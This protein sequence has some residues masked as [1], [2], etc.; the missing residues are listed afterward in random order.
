MFFSNKRTLEG[1][2][3]PEHP[4]TLSS[5]RLIEPSLAESV[6]LPQEN[7]ILIETKEIPQLFSEFKEEDET[8]NQDQT[9]CEMIQSMILYKAL[10]RA[11]QSIWNR[12]NPSSPS[13]IDPHLSHAIA[14]R[15]SFLLQNVFRRAHLNRRS[16]VKL[17]RK[18]PQNANRDLEN[19]PVNWE[20]LREAA[21]QIIGQAALDQD[22]FVKFKFRLEKLFKKVN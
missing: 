5:S 19:V 18:F 14:R 13:A 20:D 6:K 21:K 3:W 11:S 1:L 15:C 7:E 10:V 12:K 4:E 16:A 9:P 22:T 2:T 8:D 17:L